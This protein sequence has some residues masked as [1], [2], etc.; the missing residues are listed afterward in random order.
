MSDTFSFIISIWHAYVNAAHYPIIILGNMEH[1][2][3]GT[4]SH[5]SNKINVM[6]QR[7][8]WQIIQ[9]PA[10]NNVTAVYGI[11]NSILTF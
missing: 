9:S 3:F 10:C 6:R 11:V 7:V 8:E 1:A 2:T 4:C 5:P